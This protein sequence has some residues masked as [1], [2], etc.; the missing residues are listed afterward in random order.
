VTTERLPLA[1]VR[2]AAARPDHRALL[3]DGESWTYGQL[4]L[5][6]DA[7]A[8]R[9]GGLV[10]EGDRIAIAAD[11]RPELVALVHGAQRVGAVV[12]PLNVRLTPAELASQLLVLDP[13]VIV[14]AAGDME[15]VKRAVNQMPF[16][17]EAGGL[18]DARDPDEIALADL[19]V[20][21][22]PPQTETGRAESA[23]LRRTAE[24]DE[25]L[26]VVFTSGSFGRPRGVTVTHGNVAWSAAS[27]ALR[28]GHDPADEWLAVL[29]M[30][31]MGGLSIL[32]RCAWGATTVRLE[33]GFDPARTAEALETSST[34]VSLVPTMLRRLVEGSA[35]PL[36]APSLRAALVGGG[37]LSLALVQRAREAGVPVCPTYGATEAASQ[38]ATQVA[39]ES[40]EGLAAA[41]MPF[42]LVRVVR[43]GRP[44]SAGQEGEILVSGPTVMPGYFRRP[45]ATASVLVDGWLHTG[46]LG[47]MD[48]AGRL[49]V[50]GRRRDRIVTGGEN[51][52]PAEV[53]AVLEADPHVAEACVVGLP[54]DEWGMVVAAA[55]ASRP[56][57]ARDTDA[58]LESARTRLAA[59]KLPKVVMWLDVLPRTGSGKVRRDEV[60]SRF[61]PQG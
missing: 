17:A 56:G 51:V 6:A 36:H 32:F 31:H 5:W 4:A 26:A 27:S 14:V 11:A 29:P 46:D 52:S 22:G 35:G 20:V 59:Y 15:H 2:A 23:A 61:D 42:T 41:P 1:L 12:A 48:A 9:L 47:Y 33:P 54:S 40:H 3:W 37:P 45:E 50:T 53:E 49:T 43:A 18:P 60:A 25:A 7:C 28:L 34:L 39:W 10:R 21:A 57:A 44:A 13:A 55:L 38:I 8:A 19:A 58:V 24:A 16:V 30:F